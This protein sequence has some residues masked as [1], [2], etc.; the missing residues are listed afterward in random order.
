MSNPAVAGPETVAAPAEEDELERLRRLLFAAERDRLA[1]IEHRLT[2]PD[3]RIEELSRTLPTALGLA[4]RQGDQLGS[5]LS[6]VIE[7]AISAS[8]SKNRRR[9]AEA[10]APA[11]G[12]AIRRAIAE[13][14]RTMVDSFNQVLQHSFSPRALRWRVEAWRTGRPFAEVLLSHSLVFRVERV[15]LVHRSTGLLLEQAPEGDAASRDADLVSGMLS[16]I[17]DFVRDSFSVD[18]EQAVDTMRVGD[19]VVWVE[20]ADH[21]YIAAVIRG[22]PP[23][24]LRGVLREAL[25]A[26]HLDL[27]EA[28]EHFSGDASPFA[29]AQPHLEGCLQFQV[30]ER[31]ERRRWVAPAVITGLVLA[32][33]VIWATLAIV[34]SQRWHRYV[35][36][37][38][39]EPGIVVVREETGLLRSSIAGL[40]DPFAAD[41]RALL[42]PYGLDAARVASLW[43]PFVSEDP[44]IVVARAR[45]TLEAP[46]SVKLDLSNGVLSASGTA[47]HRWVAAAARRALDL[48][49]VRR[50]EAR[51]LVDEG[52]SDLGPLV[53]K[54]EAIVIRFD[55]GA[56]EPRGEA[57]ADVDRAAAALQE[58]TAVAAQAG[59]SV[60]ADVIGRT[61][62]TGSESMNIP[63]SRARAVWVVAAVESTGVRDVALTVVGAGASR[64]LRSEDTAA[65]RA[66]NRSVTIRVAELR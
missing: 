39:Y 60:R 32:G 30:A 62:G 41:P 7:Q 37:L 59:V 28:F 42:G 47:P 13:A 64:P 6:P 22:V 10:L 38:E 66:F 52:L 45:A 35:N 9:L 44:P 14:L 19:L 27:A 53:Q 49:G 34:A 55:I 57:L 12:P 29:A 20:Q 50:Y 65:G 61:D 18:A 16:A 56:P 2:D 23:V 48:P 8:V 17:Q 51:Q 26:I 24:A 5:A 36:R 1:E 11:M 63:L 40:A 58:L 31:R 25:E 33:L 46:P 15:F 43:R 21:A 4:A 54:V 3:V